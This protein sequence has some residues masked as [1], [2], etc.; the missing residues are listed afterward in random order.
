MSIVNADTTLFTTGNTAFN[1]LG[2]T[3]IGGGSCAT[4]GS[5]TET[6][7][8]AIAGIDLGLSFF[9]TRPVYVA[10]ETVEATGITFKGQNYATPFWAF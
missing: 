9:Y 4:G 5:G 2:G 8:N 3:A 1:N 7:N 10:N 6:A